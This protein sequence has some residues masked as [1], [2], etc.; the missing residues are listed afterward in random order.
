LIPVWALAVRLNELNKSDEILVYCGVG[1]RSANASG[2]LASNGFLHVYNML[3]GISEWIRQGNPVYTK[4]AS[5][6]EAIDNATAGDAVCVSAGLYVEQLVLNK[7]VVLEGENRYTT[8]VTGLATMLTVTVDNVSIRD[9]TIRYSGCACYAYSAVNVTNSQNV[10]L[11]K[12]VIESDDIGIQVVN[13]REVII[14]NNTI[15]RTGR[16]CIAVL[17]SSEISVL[18]N[19][20]TAADGIELD[21]S[22]K[23]VFSGNTIFSAN[24]AGILAYKSYENTFFHNTINANGSTAISISDSYNN[25]FFGNSLSSEGS[26]KLFFWQSNYNS[27]FHNN[28]L[29]N[30]GGQLSNYNST[31]L[32]DNGFE[33]NFWRYFT[34][35]DS[36]H[37]GIGDEVNVLDSTNRDNYPLM[38]I[39]HSF[40]TSLNQNVEIVSNSTIDEFAYLET[41][42]TIELQVSNTTATQTIGFCRISIPHSLI[43]PFNGSISV[44]V[45]SGLTQVL[46]LNNAVHDNGTHRWIYFTYTHSTHRI[47]IVPEFPT[48]FFLP[49]FMI[50]IVMLTHKRR[51]SR[52][53]ARA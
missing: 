47:L 51:R 30:H 53:L 18:D 35:V 15:T 5:I 25:T 46:F 20:I 33:G 31:N 8:I 45:D 10:N 29:F 4:Y 37:D 32:W 24:G 22:A 23:N 11:T 40:N 36:N 43:D 17:N 48:I 9:F 26:Y 50:T 28:F 6:Q 7:S 1:G 21:T 19:D 38:G 3:G 44:V 12:N 2:I 14:A 41:N 34:G 13:S 39:F 16:S 49:L 27:L 42:R 52:N